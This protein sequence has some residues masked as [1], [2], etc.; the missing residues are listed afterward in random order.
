MVRLSD[1]SALR[2]CL[3]RLEP[4]RRKA[5]LL[6]YVEGLSY[7]PT[8]RPP[9]RS[10]RHHEILD[11]PVA[12]CVAGVHAMTPEH[13]RLAGEYVVGLLDGDERRDR[14]TPRRE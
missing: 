14:R 10:P 9:R 12:R 5:I 6:A 2:R 4:L 3:E 8:R 13:E 1:V 11:S 7:W